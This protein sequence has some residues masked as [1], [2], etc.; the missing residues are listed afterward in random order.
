MQSKLETI[1]KACIEANPEIVELKFGCEVKV[2]ID[3]EEYEYTKIQYLNA[4]D[5]GIW[6]NG[7]D[8]FTGAI[9]LMQNEDYNYIE[10]IG[11]PILPQDIACILPPNWM[12][13]GHRDGRIEFI[14]MTDFGNKNFKNKYIIWTGRTLNDQT[15]ETID[16]IYN[17]IK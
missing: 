10:I 7:E 12:L 17:L 2:R 13:K 5:L 4:Y 11:R 1:R 6:V 15:D 3:D 8:V 9:R 14:D 16:F